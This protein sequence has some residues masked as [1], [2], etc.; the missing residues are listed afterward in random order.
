MHAAWKAGLIWRKATPCTLHM[1]WLQLEKIM[2]VKTVNPAT[3]RQW[4]AEGRAS[5]IDVR[6]PGEHRARRISQARNIPLANVRASDIPKDGGTLVVHYLKGARG[7]SACEKLLKEMPGLEV[8]NLAGGIDAWDAAGLPVSK[9]GGFSLPLD[10]QVQLTIGLMLL[11]GSGL[12]LWV[13]PL[14]ALLAAALGL[15]L[16]V[17]GATG[18]CGLARLMALAPWNR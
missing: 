14:F 17:A 2:Q 1:F 5:L 10:R 11:A 16:T 3:L 7:A 12:T 18:F 4:L 8:Y 9:A 6:E 13:H 15:G